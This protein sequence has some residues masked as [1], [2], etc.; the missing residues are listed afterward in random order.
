VG[1]RVPGGG[2]T[3]DA[4][5][6]RLARVLATNDQPAEAT[7]LLARLGNAADPKAFAAVAEA[8]AGRDPQA[9]ANWAIAQ[10]PGPGQSRALASIVGR[11]ANDNPQG[12]GDWLAQFPAGETRD[13][14]IAAYLARNASWTAGSAQRIAEFD[15]WFDLID[16]PWQRAQAATRNYWVRKEHDPAEART[17][18]TSLPNLDPEVVRITLRTDR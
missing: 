4:L 11:W 3:R 12:A 8:W 1:R 17:W 9:A 7:Q 15:A 16:D 5:Q 6:T 18:L 13:R 2:A 14:S 10:P